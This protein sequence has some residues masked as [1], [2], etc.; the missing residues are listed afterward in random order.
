MDDVAGIYARESTYLDRYVQVGIAGGKVISL[1]FPGAPEDDAERDH[2]LLDRIEAYLEGDREEFEDV[3]LG[4]TV[5]TDRRE[6]L[7]AV[8]EIPYGSQVSVEHLARAVPGLDA[9]DEADHDV[10]RSALADNPVPLLV[11]DH[12][13]RDGPSGAPAKVE[14][15]LR[16]LEEL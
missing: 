5:P 6:V 14:Q 13:V 12:R 4:L 10:V 11:P 2:P 9:D 8:R 15:R 16:S 3:E 7:L 1:S